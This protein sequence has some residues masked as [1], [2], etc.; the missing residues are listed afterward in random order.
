M[1]FVVEFLERLQM[2][3]RLGVP[4]AGLVSPHQPPFVGWIDNAR[5]VRRL[6]GDRESR[7]AL[8][9]TRMEASSSP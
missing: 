2:A 3:V 1:T 7:E 4:G 6:R 5:M 8:G 9:S